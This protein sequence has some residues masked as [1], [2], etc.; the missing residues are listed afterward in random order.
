MHVLS[1]MLGIVCVASVLMLSFVTGA[2]AQ[3]WV[4]LAPF[5]E[6]S[7]EVYGVAA[8]GKLYVFGGLA[9]GWKP[10]GL[11]YEYD[12]ATDKWTKKKNMPLPAHHSALAEANGKIYVMGGFVLPQSGPP[13][14]QP[15]GLSGF[16]C[17]RHIMSTERT[18]YAKASQKDA[19]SQRCRASGGVA[20]DPAGIA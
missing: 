12:P 16:L 3:K 14:W 18:R 6:A 2:H 13:A 8:G 17:V 7:E 11:V 10:K 1:R 4:K 20:E 5:P 15:M 9:P 19:E